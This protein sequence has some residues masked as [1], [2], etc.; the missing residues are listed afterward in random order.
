MPSRQYS[1]PALVP[2]TSIRVSQRKLNRLSRTKLDCYRS[3]LENG[4]D[5]PPI[6]L[7]DCGAFYTIWDGRHRFAAHSLA[8]FGAIVA[9]IRS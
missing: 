7:T 2:L 8:G 5:F 6:I 1:Q 9:R 4:D 3:D